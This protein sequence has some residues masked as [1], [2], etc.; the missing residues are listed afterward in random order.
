[1]GVGY[2]DGFLYGLDIAP[3][4]KFTVQVLKSI[5]R[6]LLGKAHLDYFLIRGLG[7]HK[8]FNSETH[9]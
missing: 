9:F 1:V 4:T 6:N 3:A 5:F 8:F 2:L 7:L